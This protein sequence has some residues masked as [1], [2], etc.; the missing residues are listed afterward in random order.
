MNVIDKWEYGLSYIV[1]EL[2]CALVLLIKNDE[3]NIIMGMKDYY[4]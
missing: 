2:K 3:F 4:M 1:G